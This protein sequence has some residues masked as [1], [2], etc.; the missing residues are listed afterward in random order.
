MLTNLRK[1]LASWVYT[2]PLKPVDPVVVRVERVFRS[3]AERF[4]ELARASDS[5]SFKDKYHTVSDEIT[6]LHHLVKEVL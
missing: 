3:E 1:K 4:R 2:E 5:Q 6:N